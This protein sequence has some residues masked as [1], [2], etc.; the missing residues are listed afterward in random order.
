[1]WGQILRLRKYRRLC[2]QDEFVSLKKNWVWCFTSESPAVNH[3][4]TS[5]SD[6]WETPRFFKSRCGNHPYHKIFSM[7][8]FY[9]LTTC[10]GGNSLLRFLLQFGSSCFFSI[11]CIFILWLSWFFF[12]WKLDRVKGIAPMRMD[13]KERLYKRKQAFLFV[14]VL[15]GEHV[16]LVASQFLGF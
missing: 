6:F 7:F 14:E 1:M 15:H 9:P 11:F 12:L 5:F 3:F 8:I 2:L 10:I 13:R 16:E 4:T